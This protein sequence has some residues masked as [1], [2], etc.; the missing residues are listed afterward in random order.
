M[1]G[2]LLKQ[3]WKALTK[4]LLP[5]NLLLIIITV[6]GRLVVRPLTTDA[7]SSFLQVLTVFM[8]TFYI[9]LLIAVT[10][11][12]FIYIVV[13][14]Y[15]TMYSDEGYLTHTLPLTVHQLII[16]KG[17]AA[18]GWLII[19]YCLAAVNVLFLIF[20]AGSG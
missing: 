14:F 1:L 4:V 12:A 10:C 17:L 11:G 19:T 20:G 13:R 6:I 15:R 5:A 18:S 8:L 2:K 3:E 9:I 7:E 16:G